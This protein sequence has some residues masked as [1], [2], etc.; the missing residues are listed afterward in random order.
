MGVV[1]LEPP[2]DL[3]R[4]LPPPSTAADEVGV[5]EQARKSQ[6]EKSFLKKSRCGEGWGKI[7]DATSV[8][9]GCGKR[10]LTALDLIQTSASLHNDALRC[11]SADKRPSQTARIAPPH[12]QVG[13]RNPTTWTG[14]RL[15]G[16]FEI[17]SHRAPC[18]D[19]PLLFEPHVGLKR[20][21]GKIKCAEAFQRLRDQLVSCAGR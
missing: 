11:A 20:K 18:Q 21:G 8:M 15:T 1:M 19:P 5:C 4:V 9:P 6:P 3:S 16:S 17:C 14:A 10:W 13:Q 12:S 2:S 7:E